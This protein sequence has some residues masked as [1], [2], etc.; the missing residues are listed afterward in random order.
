MQFRDFQPSI[1]NLILLKVVK[2]YRCLI[3]NESFLT[4][5][6]CIGAIASYGYAVKRDALDKTIVVLK[7]AQLFL[8][9]NK[10]NIFSLLRITFKEYFIK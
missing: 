4:H 6:L 8:R 10:T 3:H 2:L 1:T 7:Y 9:S 5:I